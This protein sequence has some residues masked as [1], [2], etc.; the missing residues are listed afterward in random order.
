[1]LSGEFEV[2]VVE[3]VTA[4]TTIIEGLVRT[5]LRTSKRGGYAMPSAKTYA[6]RFADF[7]PSGATTDNDS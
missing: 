4:A 1:Q 7:A 5:G 6:G 3:G 2:P